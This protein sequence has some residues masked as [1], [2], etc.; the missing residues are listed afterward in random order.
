MRFCAQRGH[1]L[2]IASTQAYPIC[3]IQ[4][5]Q[6]RLYCSLQEQLLP[7]NDLGPGCVCNSWALTVSMDETVLSALSRV[8]TGLKCKRITGSV[9]FGRMSTRLVIRSQL[10]LFL[11]QISCLRGTKG[12]LNLQEG[13]VLKHPQ[14]ALQNISHKRLYHKRLRFKKIHKT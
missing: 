2:S 1:S 10:N 6:C 5:S 8:L 4:V 3:V 11:G 13:C 14:T 12:H 7:P 9:C